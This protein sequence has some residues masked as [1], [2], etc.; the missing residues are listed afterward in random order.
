MSEIASLP[1]SLSFPAAPFKTDVFAGNT[2]PEIVAM[3]ALQ[4]S[5]SSPL[6]VWF[7]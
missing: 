7:P 1:L 5:R 6:L 4:V 3:P 2:V